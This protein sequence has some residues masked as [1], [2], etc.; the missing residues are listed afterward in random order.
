MDVRQSVEDFP[1]KPPE[2]AAVQVQALVYSVS[3]SALLTILHLGGEADSIKQPPL[4]DNNRSAF[5]V[6]RPPSHLYIQVMCD[7]VGLLGVCALH[8]ALLLSLTPGLLK[9]G[10][11]PWIR[12]AA[13]HVNVGKRTRRHL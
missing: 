4:T 5:L 11:Q 1:E 6:S 10:G 2:A 12:P 3:Q 8:R 9:G 7:K 13:V